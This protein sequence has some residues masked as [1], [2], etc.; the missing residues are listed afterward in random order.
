[1]NNFLQAVNRMVQAAAPLNYLEAPL[2]LVGRLYVATIFFMSGLTKIDDWETTLYL[3]ES[4]YAVPLLSY[5]VAA[6]LG[7]FGELVFPVLLV[8]GFFTRLS[9]LG[10]FVVNVVA[11]ISL[12][13]ISP[14]ALN[15][16]YMWAVILMAVLVT[17]GGAWTL[18]NL[19]NR[20]TNRSVQTL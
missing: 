5:P 3:F 10:L 6:F 4:E 8:L 12:S 9:A 19:L 18:D 20:V 16:H 17:G 7:T 11:V 14:A 15:Q 2:W 13:E 1:M